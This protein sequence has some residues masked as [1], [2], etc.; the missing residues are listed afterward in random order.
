MWR[1][2]HVH[3]PLLDMRRLLF[4]WLCLLRPLRLLCQAL[5]QLLCRALVGGLLG[6]LLLCGREPPSTSVAC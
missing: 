3:L 1:R 4:W 2:L 6:L 5:L